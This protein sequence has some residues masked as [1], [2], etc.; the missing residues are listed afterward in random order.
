MFSIAGGER[1]PVAQLPQCVTPALVA[2]LERSWAQQP[3]A[4]PKMPEWLDVLDGGVR[5]LERECEVCMDMHKLSSGALCDSTEHFQC[6]ACV[7]DRLNEAVAAG[8]EVR[9]DGAL[10]CGGCGG[11]YPFGAFRKVLDDA[12]FSAWNRSLMQSRERELAAQFQAELQ[13][14][15]TQAEAQ[16]HA[17]YVRNEILTISCPRCHVAF[18]YEGGCLAM[19]CKAGAC[20]CG[21]CAYCFADCGRDAHTHVAGCA[22]NTANRNV[23]PPGEHNAT[24]QAQQL[25][26]EGVQRV[27]KTRVLKGHL[28]TLPAALQRELLVLIADDLR[29]NGIIID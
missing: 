3:Q 5:A 21:F 29:H 27:R 19:N 22:F 28:L 12:T 18:L 13:R 16:R 6:F 14:Q 11:L 15:M 24:P 10:S 1:P 23:F 2:L 20:P 9:S 26:F 25:Y 4:R 17:Q 7:S 8:Q